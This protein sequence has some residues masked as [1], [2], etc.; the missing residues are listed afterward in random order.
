MTTLKGENV[1]HQFTTT[2][3]F[4]SGLSVS[5]NPSHLN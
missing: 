1:A 5:E 2:N 4:D 3:L